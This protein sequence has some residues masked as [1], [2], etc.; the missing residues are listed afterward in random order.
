LASGARLMIPRHRLRVRVA[1][2]VCPALLWAGLAFASTPTVNPN[3]MPA[4]NIDQAR[5]G[6]PTSPT[7]P[8]DF[9]NGNAGS[10]N[11][12]YAEGHSIPYRIRFTDL[13]VGHH[14]AI[15]EWDIKHSDK[16]A[17]DFIMRVDRLQP[18]TF[19][20]AHPQETVNPLAG[21]A[22]TFS[23]PNTTAIP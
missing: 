9:Q 11:S 13:A 22:G 20:P 10:S 15:I 8:V 17:I 3:A 21:L 14:Y 7:S 1:T 12:H 23:G 2:L 19:I 5:N 6:T 18:H 16:N 4:A